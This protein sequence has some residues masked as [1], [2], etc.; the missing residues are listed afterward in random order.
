MSSTF[1]SLP[2]SVSILIFSPAA[3][4][5]TLVPPVSAR[6]STMEPPAS[7]RGYILDLWSPT[8]VW[9]SF[10]GEL[11]PLLLPPAAAPAS[12]LFPPVSGWASSLVPDHPDS[13]RVW[14]SLSG[15]QVPLLPADSDFSPCPFACLLPGGTVRT[16][17]ASGHHR[18]AYSV[19]SC[20]LQS[21]DITSAYS[22]S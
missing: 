8:R 15:D 20:P 4:H 18:H 11:V 9:T 6:S 1:F 7:A 10:R 21:L 2:A 13:Y 19:I 12:T 17:L 5:P 3:R 14:P 22:V 16:W